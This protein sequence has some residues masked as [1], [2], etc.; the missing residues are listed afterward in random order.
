MANGN[1]I[2]IKV[3]SAAA[4][5]TGLDRVHLRRGPREITLAATQTNS[6]SL[7]LTLPWRRRQCNATLLRCLV[8][9]LKLAKKKL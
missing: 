7:G 2:D 9:L 3:L 6:V 1:L 4:G 8:L 5:L